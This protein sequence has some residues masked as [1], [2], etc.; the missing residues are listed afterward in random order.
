M[1]MRKMM[2]KMK[3]PIPSLKKRKLLRARMRTKKKKKKLRKNPNLTATALMLEMLLM[4]ILKSVGSRRKTIASRML[5]PVK[6][7]VLIQKTKIKLLKQAM[8]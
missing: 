6:A 4:S 8:Q 2:K 1:K 7:K 3:M 5:N